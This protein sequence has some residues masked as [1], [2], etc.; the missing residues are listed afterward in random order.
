MKKRARFRKRGCAKHCPSLT[1]LDNYLKLPQNYPKITPKILYNFGKKRAR[2]RKRG[3]AKH[4]PS[5]TILE[6]HHRITQKYYIYVIFFNDNDKSKFIIFFFTL[7]ISKKIYAIFLNDKFNLII[8]LLTFK[9]SEI[10]SDL[11]STFQKKYIL[12]S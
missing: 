7:N 9:C 12:Y 10:P 11:T 8:F 1:I 4:C 3:C 2:F 5:L 6:K